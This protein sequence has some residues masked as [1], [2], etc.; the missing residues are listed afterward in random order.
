MNIK[1]PIY[2]GASEENMAKG[3]V[4]LTE[5]SYPVEGINTNCVIAAHRGY[6]KAA[7]FRNI[8]RM[9]TGDLVFIENM[10]EKLT[11]RVKECKVISPE[12]TRCLKIEEDKELLTLFTCH[13][14][15]HN[16]QRYVVICEKAG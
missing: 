6:S 4:H 16:Y 7:M 15:R 3:A 8:E 12:D 2:L 9:E 10:W 14:Y 11:Y 1:L 5:T 13:P